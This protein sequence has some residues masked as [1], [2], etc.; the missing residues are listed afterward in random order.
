MVGFIQLTLFAL[1]YVI[2]FFPILTKKFPTGTQ[3]ISH[4]MH[5]DW[6]S[7][8]NYI[9]QWGWGKGVTTL[10]EGLSKK[11]ILV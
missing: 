3:D 2:V 5:R 9:T 6:G 1:T 7:H 4:K 11:G 8:T 10:F